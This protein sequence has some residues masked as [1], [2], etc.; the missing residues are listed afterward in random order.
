MQ[1]PHRRALLDALT[2]LAPIQEP[3]LRRKMRLDV[4]YA[5]PDPAKVRMAR[6]WVRRLISWKEQ[7]RA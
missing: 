7:E 5:E 2:A 1:T 4:K 3:E 6:P